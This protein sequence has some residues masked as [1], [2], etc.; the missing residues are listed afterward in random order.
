MNLRKCDDEDAED[1]GVICRPRDV[2]ALVEM[3]RR[4]TY[5]ET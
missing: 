3:C 5:S 1:D 4:F 2:F